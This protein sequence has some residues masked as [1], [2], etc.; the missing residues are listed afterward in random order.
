M[1]LVAGALV[2]CADA[3]DLENRAVL[4]PH[5]GEMAALLQRRRSD[6]EDE[7]ARF[8]QMAAQRFNAVVALKGSATYIA[9]PQGRMLVN[10]HGHVGLATSGSGDALAGIIAGLLARGADPLMSAAWG[11]YL[12]AIAGRALAQ[13]VGVG[14]LAREVLAQI[15]PVMKRLSV[16]T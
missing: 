5:A 9:Q 3:G 12:H 11:V 10:R 6:I 8:A 15:P 2:A 7:P 4:T 13:R 16:S 14:F 1:R